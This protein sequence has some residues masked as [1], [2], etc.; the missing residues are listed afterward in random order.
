MP[1]PTYRERTRARRETSILR[2]A[3]RLIREQG[4]SRLNMDVLAD[5]V[6]IAKST[7]YGHFASK[8]DLVVAVLLRA[9]SLMETH[10]AQGVG[11]PLSQLESTLRY[12]LQEA[13]APYGFATT[14]VSDEVIALFYEHADVRPRIQHMTADLEK[15]IDEAKA[16]HQID[17]DI[18][19]H[20]VISLMFGMLNVIEWRGFVDPPTDRSEMI[21]HAIAIW[22]RGIA[23]PVSN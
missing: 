6:G 23:P 18:P 19:N 3:A 20:L 21:R 10:M 13:Y 1:K 9:M 12:L 2:A 11:D 4:Y 15:L 17:P 16:G 14:L 5:E 8:H 22:R 7:L